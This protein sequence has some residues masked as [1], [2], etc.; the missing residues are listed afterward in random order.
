MNIRHLIKRIGKYTF[1]SDFDG[2]NMMDVRTANNQNFDV[3][4]A[5]DCQGTPMNTNYRYWWCFSI[6]GFSSIDEQIVITVRYVSS[7]GALFRNG[8]R[9]TFRIGNFGPWERISS[10]VTVTNHENSASITFIVSINSIL[11][12]LLHR[13]SWA[14][15]LSLIPNSPIQK[16]FEK[17][18]C[19]EDSLNKAKY[20]FFSDSLSPM[21]KLHLITQ[22]FPWIS[23]TPPEYFHFIIEQ[24][25]WLIWMMMWAHQHP[26]IEAR[27]GKQKL[28]INCF[29]G[30]S[31]ITQGKKFGNGFQIIIPPQ[32]ARILS[33][34]I[35]NQSSL[36]SQGRRLDM[37]TIS[38]FYGISSKRDDPIAALLQQK[39][40][41][42][43]GEIPSS[44][45]LS[46]IIRFALRC[47]DIRSVLFRERYV[48]KIVP[49]VNPDGVYWGF[50]RSDTQGQNLNRWYESE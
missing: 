22:I 30:G 37:I 33:P 39:N 17:I 27:C 8:M 24:E 20:S 46:G 35:L 10:Q 41:L 2:G 14:D 31:E 5:A 45:V 38:S 3:Y 1:S 25:M 44:F 23:S 6:R 15:S 32:Q 21:H 29:V 34:I 48:L 12:S 42:H 49:L 26:A 36:F 18:I 13:L 43:P 28:G 4:P 7:Q 19:Q 47:T 50:S 40:D 11:T 9:P 16:Q